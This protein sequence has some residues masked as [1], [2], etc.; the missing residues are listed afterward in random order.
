MDERKLT[1]ADYWQIQEAM[2]D[3]KNEGR[4]NR[5]EKITDLQ[6]VVKSAVNGASVVRDFDGI[7]SATSSNSNVHK[8]R[9]F[10]SK[11]HDPDNDRER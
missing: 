10:F 5:R 6:P 2:R 11:D 9:R 3:L 7:K 1:R 8:S 4:W